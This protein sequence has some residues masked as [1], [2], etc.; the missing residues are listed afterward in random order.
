MPD[1]INPDHYKQG[2]E[3]ID[4]LLATQGAEAVKGFCL[5]N[6]MKY[7]YRHRNKNGDEDIRK[8]QW[9]LNKYLSL[10]QEVKAALYDVEEIHPNC[11][12]QVWK[13]SVTGE[14]SVGWWENK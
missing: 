9:Y 4:I 12:V 11:T 13:N 6:A 2:T 10:S 3:C 14:E 1:K 5:C 7:L 8:A